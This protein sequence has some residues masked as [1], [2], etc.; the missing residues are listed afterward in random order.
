MSD[1]KVSSGLVN[2]NCK[3]RD[4][5]YELPIVDAHMHIQSNDIAPLPIMN[6][7]LRY[8]IA[9]KFLPKGFIN[10]IFLSSRKIPNF[11]Y[12]YNPKTDTIYDGEKKLFNSNP[13]RESLVAKPE[14]KSRRFLTDATAV[15]TE[16][17]VV[18]RHLSYSI[19]GLYQN[20][21][22]S[23]NLAYASRWAKNKTASE[24]DIEKAKKSRDSIVNARHTKDWFNNYIQWYKSATVYELKTDTSKKVFAF[25]S[26][27]KIAC[28]MGMELMYAHFWGAYGIPIYLEDSKGNIYIIDNFP[29]NL[30]YPYDMDILSINEVGDVDLTKC[31]EKKCSS[32]QKYSIFLQKLDDVS[33][34]YQ[35]EDHFQ[36]VEYQKIAALRYP[37]QFLPFYHVDPRRFFAPI[38]EIKKKF[39]FYI[40]TSKKGIYHKLYDGKENDNDEDMEK[41]KESVTN[42]IC[43]MN[44]GN[45]ANGIS[46]KYSTSIANV[47]KELLSKNNPG[48]FWGIKL[49]VA[50]GYPPY[51]GC[52]GN[53]NGQ[54]VF[55]ELN[56]DT[57]KDFT[58]F[59]GWCGDN[60]VPVTCHCSPQG[61]T[62]ADSEIYLKEYLKK[63]E[64]SRFKE[65]KTS[66]FEPHLKG[67]MLGLGIIDDFSSP[68]SWEIVLNEIPSKELRL[69]LAHFGGK[70]YF[71]DKYSM[72]NDPYAW[73]VQLK[74]IIYGSDKR[75]YTD[76][77][78]FMFKKVEFPKVVQE[79]DFT[80][81]IEK[82]P[83]SKELFIQEICAKDKYYRTDLS[84]NDLNVYDIND[85][86]Q[87][88]K[89]QQILRLR[90]AMLETGIV[91]N[92]INKA[93]TRLAKL[94]EDDEEHNNLLRYRIL[95]GSD[96][97]MFEGTEGVKGIANYQAS[98]F[99]FY[100]LLT[101]KLKNKWDAWHQFTVINPLKFLGLLDLKGWDE[102]AGKTEPE[103]FSIRVDKMNNFNE[104]LKNYN[105]ELPDDGDRKSLWNLGTQEDTNAVIDEKIKSFAKYGTI[106]NAQ[107]I[108]D[109]KGNMILTGEKRNEYRCVN[110]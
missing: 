57:Y 75:I 104:A 35:F 107:N 62:I 108:V 26:K 13:F 6:G 84:L 48:L 41:I 79:N 32:S 67:F 11:K 92:D 85:D 78:N 21:S 71:V 95:F 16:Y 65:R 40:P 82:Y 25:F 38:N 54:L 14:I 73:Q 80:K 61:M 43:K 45:E 91:G 56:K 31:I 19:A 93:A 22:I 47:K 89:R 81:I 15:V 88:E 74:N 64:N 36:H 94:L 44:G 53:T 109:K 4:L 86:K 105:K 72:E 17:G 49:Y 97:P 3:E 58:D 27:P 23:T 87:Y 20:E 83:E 24:K 46:F 37:F 1:K 102:S 5:P 34:T 10:Y 18:T 28:I 8:K 70:P 103:F 52:T 66:E 33:E 98:T 55:P 42:S 51:I 101:H 7:I 39:N 99:M 76:L 69:C 60:D 96:Y 12:D 106:P 2:S 9:L 68:D 50:L 30:N 100:Q 29:E 77:S 110:D 63:K 90:F 59:L